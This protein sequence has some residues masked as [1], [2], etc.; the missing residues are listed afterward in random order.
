M[1]SSPSPKQLWGSSGEAK[2]VVVGSA[3]LFEVY[4]MMP[5][6]LSGFALF[7]HKLS[8]TSRSQK[9]LAVVF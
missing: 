9:E 8:G 4:R 7:E 5:A 2:A 1:L 6:I 3:V